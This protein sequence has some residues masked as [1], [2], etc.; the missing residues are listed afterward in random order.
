MAVLDYQLKDERCPQRSEE[1]LRE[2]FE[3]FGTVTNVQAR[4][5]LGPEADGRSWALVTF[6][7]PAAVDRVMQ[8]KVVLPEFAA[9]AEPVGCEGLETELVRDSSPQASI[10][11]I[12]SF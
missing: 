2:I 9:G 10:F 7:V 1:Q 5:K 8:Q 3:R 12:T 6:A 11:M 4:Q